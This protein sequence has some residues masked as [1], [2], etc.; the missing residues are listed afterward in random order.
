MERKLMINILELLLETYPE[1]YSISRLTKKLDVS[2]DGEF[3]K[4]IRY[5]KERSKIIVEGADKLQQDSKITITP[6]GIDF[7][8][9]I[10]HLESEEKRNNFLLLATIT[11]AISA[12]LQAVNTIYGEQAAFNTINIAIQIGQIILMLILV[13]IIVKI[14][15]KG[16][17]KFWGRIKKLHPKIHPIK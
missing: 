8:F 5:L 12:I 1:S 11:I 15:Y 13:I 16:S 4:V 7:L 17:E 2:I 6:N 14:I 3:S 10:K 9:E